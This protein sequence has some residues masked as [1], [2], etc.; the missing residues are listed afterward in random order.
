M[1]ITSWYLSLRFT[2][3]QNWT[4]QKELLIKNNKILVNFALEQ[5][6]PQHS[7][8]TTRFCFKDKDYKSEN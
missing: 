2:P 3:S 1:I 7:V 4:R 6:W 8:T 5:A